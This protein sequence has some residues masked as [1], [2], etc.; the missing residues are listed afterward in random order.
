M[1]TI[2]DKVINPLTGRLIA[3][4]GDTYN[5]LISQGYKYVNGSLILSSQSIQ[6][7][8][9][10]PTIK[11]ILP[12]IKPILPTAVQPPI[13]P[14]TVS[15]SIPKVDI[16]EQEIKIL[17]QE[18][19]MKRTQLCRSCKELYIDRWMP[20]TARELDNLN[21]IIHVCD[22]CNKLC[23][24]KYSRKGISNSSECLPYKTAVASGKQQESKLRSELIVKGI[25]LG[26]VSGQDINQYFPK[27]PNNK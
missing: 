13:E 12:T 19:E 15:G 17:Q 18:E 7:K 11:P 10:A 6:P 16:L 14:K 27:I 2:S 21:K 25:R 22:E 20:F 5:R 23:D 3:V 1:Q 24:A 9:S 4:N 26:A 8:I